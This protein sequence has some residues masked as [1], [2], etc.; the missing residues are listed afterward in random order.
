M[1][2]LTFD[3]E[4]KLP[5]SDNLDIATDVFEEAVENND[6]QPALVDEEGVVL[7]AWDSGNGWDEGEGYTIIIGPQVDREWNREFR[8]YPDRIAEENE[9][10]FGDWRL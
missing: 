8:D 4:G 7:V 9:Y 5:I 10:R 2:Y 3:G 1:Y 6:W